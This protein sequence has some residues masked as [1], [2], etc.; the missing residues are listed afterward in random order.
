VKISLG[1]GGVRF[2]GWTHVDADPQWQPDVCMDLRDP[3]PFA[4]ASADFM[5]S[6]DFIGQLTLD[7][8]DAF[9]RECHRV[10]KPGGVLRLLTPD[11]RLL[12]DM[13]VNADLRLRELWEREVGIPLKTRTLGEVVNLAITF[14]NHK[15]FYDEETLRALMEPIGFALD[16]VSCQ[17][18]AYPP[19]R[20]LDLRGP[21]NAISMY[22]DCVR[23]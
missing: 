23:N 6:E 7:E 9:F 8:A 12:L 16:R 13:Y 21:D 19:L 1:S 3:L 20:G 15:F 10:L 22:F 2:D 4:D 18:S 5:Q 14:A 11:L 17:Q